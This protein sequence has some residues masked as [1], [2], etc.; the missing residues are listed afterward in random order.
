MLLWPPPV[1]LERRRRTRRLPCGGEPGGRPASG[2][3]GGLACGVPRSPWDLKSPATRRAPPSAN[4]TEY[5]GL[6]ED[7]LGV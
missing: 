4:G 7:A 6:R 3:K 5:L 1:G 2:G